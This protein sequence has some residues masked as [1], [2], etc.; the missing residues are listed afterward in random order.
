[1]FL[2]KECTYLDTAKKSCRAD[3]APIPESK[4]KLL[5]EIESWWRS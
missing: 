3:P 2:V 4:N 1:L 5:E